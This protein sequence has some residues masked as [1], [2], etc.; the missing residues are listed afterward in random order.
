MAKWTAM[1]VP[2]RFGGGTR[3]KI[4]EAFARRIPVVSTRFG[5]FGYEVVHDREV[6]LADT[7]AEFATACVRLF[8]E[9]GL[10]ERLTASASALYQERYSAHALRGRVATVVSKVMRSDYAQEYRR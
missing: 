7:P 8:R 6:L 5:A 9:A 1:I 2:I 10:A 4:A 3:M